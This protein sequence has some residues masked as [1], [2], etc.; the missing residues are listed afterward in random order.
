MTV[1]IRFKVFGR[2]TAEIDAAAY[3]EL[4][5][6]LGLKDDESVPAV[7]VNITMSAMQLMAGEVIA[8]E[9]DVEV[10]A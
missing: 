8:Y 7:K 1:T 9:A 6:V 3:A 10:T 4:R 2:T 5:K